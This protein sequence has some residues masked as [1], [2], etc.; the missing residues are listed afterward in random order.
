MMA[1]L[2]STIHERRLHV[3]FS[4][5][6]SIFTLS[7]VIALYSYYKRNKEEKEVLHEPRR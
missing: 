5:P 6:H 4:I 7:F 3:E 1:E 2:P